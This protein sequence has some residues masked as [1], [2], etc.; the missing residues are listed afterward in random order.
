MKKYRIVRT[1]TEYSWHDVVANSEQEA[2]DLYHESP[3]DYWV[4]AAYDD[5]TQEEIKEN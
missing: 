4:G 3:E 1:Q 5:D 2:W